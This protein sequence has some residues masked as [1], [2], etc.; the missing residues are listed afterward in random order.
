VIPSAVAKKPKGTPDRAHPEGA[1][2]NVEQPERNRLRLLREKKGWTQKQLADR[3]GL[4]AAA[5]S[6]FESSDESEGSSR[7]K[8]P[9]KVVYA[10]IVAALKAKDP[11]PTSD[12]VKLSK[13]FAEFVE[14]VS[15]MTLAELED[16]ARIAQRIR[17]PV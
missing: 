9:R 15:E 5:I 10:K 12:E 2:M 8:Q 14:V 7:T 3:A 11:I 6:N 13:A 16:L 4:S 1:L 17:K